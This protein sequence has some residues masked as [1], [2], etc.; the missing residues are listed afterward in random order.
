MPWVELGWV[1]LGAIL[2]MFAQVLAAVIDMVEFVA[3][4]M[5]TN[6]YKIGAF[7]LLVIVAIGGSIWYGYDWAEGVGELRLEALRSGYGAAAAGAAKRESERYGMMEKAIIVADGKY[8]EDKITRDNWVASR[9]ERVRR[10]AE[11]RIRGNGVQAPAPA[12]GVCPEISEQAEAR[13]VEARRRV[14]ELVG[15]AHDY[16]SG[17]MACDRG[18]PGGGSDTP[19]AI[20]DMGQAGQE[21]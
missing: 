11:A 1:F 18:W 3:K 19:R 5:G 13:L 16:Q 21:R 9:I 7:A 2:C 8:N 4:M 17:L 10:D 20:P 14:I 12:P 15:W 6:L